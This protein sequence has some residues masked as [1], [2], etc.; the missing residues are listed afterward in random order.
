MHAKDFFVH[1][2]IFQKKK[3]FL[4]KKEKTSFRLLQVIFLHAN[5][6]VR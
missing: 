3:K 1:G 6:A 2:H 4:S 5:F